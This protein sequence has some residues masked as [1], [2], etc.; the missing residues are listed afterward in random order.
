MESIKSSPKQTRKRSHKSPSTRR[1]NKQRWLNWLSRRQH[2][3]SA[4]E[5][6][7]SCS[8]HQ[9]PTPTNVR[10]AGSPVER[11]RSKS[12]PDVESNQVD[13]VSGHVE[14]T[15]PI[16]AQCTGS[17]EPGQPENPRDSHSSGVDFTPGEVNEADPYES[18]PDSP[19]A[20]FKWIAE[21]PKCFNCYTPEAGAIEL[22]KC[23][24]CFIATY[25]DRRCQA[26]HWQEHRHMCKS[27]S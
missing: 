14:S 2:R 5:R 15:H 27:S 12:A 7:D 19:E 25:C 1:R 24:R 6:L 18:E 26:E 3:Q 21:Q 22:K 20:F 23:T 4:K 8:E 11:Q 16:P 13:S 9:L 17:P 10:N